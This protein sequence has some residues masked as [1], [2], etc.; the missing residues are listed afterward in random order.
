[1]PFTNPLRFVT[2]ALPLVIC[3]SCLGQSLPE[4]IN[5]SQAFAVAEKQYEKLLAMQNNTELIPF[6][7]N[8]DGT[9]KSK[10]SDWWTS[11][12][13]GGSLWYLYEYTNDKKWKEAAHQ[14][15]MAIEKEKANTNTHDLGFMLY[16]SFGN[17]YRL[18][19]EE[20][21]KTI[22]LQGAKSLASRFNPAT[23]CI[24]S[25]NNFTSRNPQDP[26]YSFPVIIDNMMNL[27]FLTWAT[28]A[29]GDSSFYRIAATHANTTLRNHFRIDN[30]SYHVVCY[31]ESNGNVL[32]KR[33]AQGAA[34]ESSWARGQA[35]GLYGYTVMFRETRLTP[36]LEQAQKI[37]DFWINHPRMPADKIVYWDFD[38]PEIPNAKRDASAA[39]ITASALLELSQY[40]SKE[41]SKRYSTI[42]EQIVQ[43]LS[44]DVYRAQPDENGN[45]IIKHGVGH[46]P[47]GTE[48]D[49][50]LVY[51]DYYYLEALL[52]YDKQL[53]TKEGKK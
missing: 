45:F 44:S 20:Q 18:L 15:T 33:T 51:A 39:A 24:K 22:M 23:G 31:D 13:F 12:F 36:Y 5:I 1:M 6:T 38:A 16:C 32:A 3:F 27:E 43:S 11:G 2:L 48:I 25:W 7:L 17:G 49:V 21:Y 41:K 26:K 46:K 14:W 8:P 53:K 30:S 29:S 52:R 50:P 42:A 47:A 40:V 4:P 35:W 34:D 37:A 10:K 19:K 9:P 28:K